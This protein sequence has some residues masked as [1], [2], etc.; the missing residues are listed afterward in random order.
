MKVAILE[1]G[2][3]PGDLVTHFGDYPAMMERMLGGDFEYDTL[4]VAA[5][6]LP[7]DPAA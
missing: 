7:A 1:T 3:P 4:D 2:R 6:H 5:G